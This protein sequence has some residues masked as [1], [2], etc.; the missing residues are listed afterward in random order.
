MHIP[1][2]KTWKR[3]SLSI[4]L[5][6][7]DGLEEFISRAE[8]CG[9]KQ[10]PSKTEVLTRLGIAARYDMAGLLKAWQE[11]DNICSKAVEAGY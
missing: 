1:R 7:L 4:G 9:I 2:P 3:L 5:K 6:N 11:I 10:V 8:I